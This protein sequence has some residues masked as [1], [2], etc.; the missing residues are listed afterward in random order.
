L[1]DDNY[2]TIFKPVTEQDPESIKYKWDLKQIK[3]EGQQGTAGWDTK[4]S[5]KSSTKPTQSFD[6]NSKH[7]AFV[8]MAN[9]VV[10]VQVL[11]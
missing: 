8:A 5:A 11:V 4:V 1:A 6:S 10:L 2:W 7:T 9:L 3:I